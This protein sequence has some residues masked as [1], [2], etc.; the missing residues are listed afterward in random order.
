M[1]KV[2]VILHAEIVHETMVN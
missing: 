2:C 1:R